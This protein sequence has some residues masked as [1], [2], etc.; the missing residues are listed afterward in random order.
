MPD[1]LRTT[2]DRK[3][4]RGRRPSLPLVLAVVVALLALAAGLGWYAHREDGGIMSSPSP[5]Y[6]VRRGDLR[7][8][9]LEGG[10]IKAARSENIKSQ[11]SRA[12]SNLSRVGLKRLTMAE[13]FLG[14]PSFIGLASQN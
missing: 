9:L 14:L 6:R 4:R 2:P 10:S 3:P 13:D 12:S 5:L 1:P 11:R 7:I 8:S